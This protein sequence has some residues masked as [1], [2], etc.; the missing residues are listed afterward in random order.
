[1]SRTKQRPVWPSD[2]QLRDFD[3]DEEFTDDGRKVTE[4]DHVGGMAPDTDPDRRRP[5]RPRHRSR[6]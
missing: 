2:D 6:R 5:P 1:M 4:A 3:D